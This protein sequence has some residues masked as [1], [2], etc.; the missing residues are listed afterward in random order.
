MNIKEMLAPVILT[1]ARSGRQRTGTVGVTV[2]NTGNYKS[3]TGAENHGKYLQNSG[4]NLQASWHYAV[5]DKGVVRCIPENEI[6]W[7]AGDKGGDG[8]YKT[9]AIEICVNPD[10][11]LTVATNNAAELAADILKRHGLTVENLYQHNHWSGKDCPAEIRKGNPFSWEVFKAVVDRFLNPV[12]I[13]VIIPP[14]PTATKSNE[15]LALEVIAGVWGSGEDRKSRLTSAGYD[16]LAVQAIVN[17]K[18]NKPS[19]APVAVF[20]T[21]STMFSPLWLNQGWNGS[22]PTKK[23]LKMSKGSRVELIERTNSNWFKVKFNGV[24]GWAAAEYLK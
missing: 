4:K 11:N 6:A 5:D 1:G 12:I 16:Y 14:N 24:I 21:V 13:P 23:V 7:H 3:G 22:M 8:N 19:A 10:S 17:Q 18:L 15:T 20:L 9:I 2:H